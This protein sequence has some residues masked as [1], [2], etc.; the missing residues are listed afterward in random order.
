M[1]ARRMRFQLA[2]MAA[3]AAAMM[4]AGCQERL[5]ATLNA[6][7]SGT[8]VYELTTAL[9]GDARRQVEEIMLSARG[10][11]AWT[12]VA[13]SASSDA[14]VLQFKGKV[15]F[16]DFNKFRAPSP[17]ML[18]SP[19]M[20]DIRQGPKQVWLIEVKPALRL[21]TSQ[22]ATAPTAAAVQE[23]MASIRQER[24]QR[25]AEPAA[26][27]IRQID[28]SSR[29]DITLHLPGKV[30]A[31]TGFLKP[32]DDTLRLELS[33]EKCLVAEDAIIADDAALAAILGAGE[34]IKNPGPVYY[35]QLL[36]RLTDGD[37]P[38]SAEVRLNN[39]GLF[40][41]YKSESDIVAEQYGQ[42]LA[43]M[44]LI[45]A[46]MPDGDPSVGIVTMKGEAF[47]EPGRDAAPTATVLLAFKP[48]QAD[49][50]LI[51]G[52][53]WQVIGA[54]GQTLLPAPN[55]G[56]R[57]QVIAGP[58]SGPESAAILAFPAQAGT[59]VKEIRGAMHYLVASNRQDVDLGE[60]EMTPGAKGAALGMVVA[61]V[62]RAP[63]AALIL[64]FDKAY[65]LESLRLEDA[66]GN[67]IASFE[68][69][70][71]HPTRSR[72]HLCIATSVGPQMRFPEL[73]EK[74]HL[75]AVLLESPRVLD[76]PFVL[77][78]VQFKGRPPA[79]APSTRP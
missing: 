61:A 32:A 38:I 63:Q 2:A 66:D 35:A 46:S 62:K 71:M 69:D 20:I 55:V 42:L 37:K 22:P 9:E 44:G 45:P 75:R 40:D 49:G 21:A 53:L 33:G 34:S 41:G 17:S 47:V 65:A 43:S 54:K 31:F 39:K 57:I 19:F 14:N 64:D 78:N 23:A 24:R 67:C 12:D 4:A 29:T 58:G 27:K 74:C 76:A 8:A 26:E 16:D 7:R 77:K 48:A 51:D 50:R 60:V 68:Y 73:P 6:D 70:P 18:P 1:M 56:R 52:E 13:Y 10:V 3:I 11:K 72:E 5:D 30:T 59:T 36:K 15:Y 79:S 28:K 25:L